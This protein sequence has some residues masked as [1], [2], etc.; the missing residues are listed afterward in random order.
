[1]M[2]N[3]NRFTLYKTT[4]DG[5]N[6][7]RVAFGSRLGPVMTEQRRTI[8]ELKGVV[9]VSYEMARRYVTGS[10]RPSWDKVMKIAHWLGVNPDWL[11]YGEG[12]KTLAAQNAK[13]KVFNLGDRSFPMNIEP[14]MVAPVPCDYA[15][16]INTSMAYELS[17]G[18]IAFCRKGDFDSGDVVLLEANDPNAFV[19]HMI[20]KVAFDSAMRPVFK[21]SNSDH[22]DVTVSDYIPIAKVV[23][24]LRK[25]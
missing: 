12:E 20:R 22:P 24:S 14:T 3:F 17:A 10:G 13:V 19:P 21:S 7:D 18:D 4:F 9:D 25:T 2:N 6:A 16:L 11:A 23:A 15:V 5:K 1:M 8:M